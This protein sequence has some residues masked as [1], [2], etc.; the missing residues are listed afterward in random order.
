MYEIVS[1]IMRIPTRIF[2]ADQVGQV[3]VPEEYGDRSALCHRR[4]RAIKPVRLDGYSVRIPLHRF[5]E[6][7][8]KENF[9]RRCPPETGPGGQLEGCGADRTFRGPQPC[10]IRPEEVMEDSPPPLQLDSGVRRPG[11]WKTGKRSPREGVERGSVVDEERQDRMVHRGGG[12]F[13]PVFP[14]E[15]PVLIDDPP[16]PVSYTH[17]RAHETRHD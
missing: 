3:V 14:R 15:L 10:G 17:L 11:K 4:V 6:R 1:S 13:A 5:S 2:E 9:V 7:P 16:H 8:R 12:K